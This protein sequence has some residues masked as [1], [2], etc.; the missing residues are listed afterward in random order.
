MIEAARS[1]NLLSTLQKLYTERKT[2]RYAA[3]NKTEE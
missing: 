1:L 2:E 3:I